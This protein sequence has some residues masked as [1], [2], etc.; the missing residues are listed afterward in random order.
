MGLFNPLY[1]MLESLPRSVAYLQLEHNC[2]VE[3]QRVQLSAREVVPARR[4][5]ARVSTL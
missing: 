4:F 1:D 2:P 5:S 3:R